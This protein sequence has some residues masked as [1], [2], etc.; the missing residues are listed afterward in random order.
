M[1]TQTVD[2]VYYDPY[3]P[4]ITTDPYP[5]FRRL[6]EEAP[7][8]YNE[9]FDFY[10]VSRFDDVERGLNDRETY[11]S[12]RGAILEIIKSGAEFPPGV[13]IFE[14]PPVHT[15]H[16]NLLQR[17]FTPKRMNALEARIHRICAQCLDPLS[18]SA[19]FDL[20]EDYGAHMPMRVIGELLGIPEQDH[21]SVRD[22]VDQSLRTEVGKPMAFNESNYTGEGFEEYIDWRAKHPAD[23][24]MTE[25]MNAEFKDE[26]GITRKLTRE[27]ILTMV[28][29]LAGAGNETTTRLIGWTGKVL[30]EHP[31]QRRMIAEDLSLIPQA[32]EEILR[33]EPPAPHMARYVTRDVEL[34]GRGVPKGSVM[35]FLPGS[36]NRDDR[37]FTDGDRFDIRREPRPHLSF[38]YGI[39]ACIGRVLARLEGRVALEALIRRFPN[40]EVDYGNARLSPTST[41]RGWET[42]PI[43]TGSASRPAA[44]AAAAAQPGAAAGPFTID[45]TWKVTVKGPTGP[46]ST[47]L[48]IAHD[49]GVVTGSQSGQGESSPI[50]DGKLDGN[51]L[52][53]INQIS[54]PMKMKLTFTAEIE[55]NAM[56]GKV[57][58]GFMGSFPFTGVKD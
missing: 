8:Y 37:R 34:Y 5:V 9:E 28:N 17:L 56:T 1:S 20:I 48:T 30:A 21:G 4:E 35:M 51:Q 36:A 50:L 12:G 58:A 32:I 44:S 11:S 3:K 38:G 25:L 16:R 10:A 55:N 53:W 27:E 42:M 43:F 49:K 26:T 31:E 52:S 33:F 40:W 46:Q 24:V 19:G 2:A 15:M 6:R 13:L 39:H 22:R 23:D 14:D 45:G 7:L 18:R 47:T 41:V 29:V 54:K 57:K